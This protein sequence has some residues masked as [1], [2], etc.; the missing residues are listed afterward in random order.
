MSEP[1]GG[2]PYSPPG[3]ASYPE[4]P[5]VAPWKEQP[6]GPWQMN[7][8]GAFE[9][10]HRNPDWLVSTLLGSLCV[11]STIL[12]PAL[13]A[14]VLNGYV[15]ESIELLH[16][17]NGSYYPKFDFGRFV[18]YL[19]RGVGP[20]LVG[21][22]LSIP[23]VIVI[24]LGYFMLFAGIFAVGAAGEENPGAA[25]LGILLAFVVF[26]T[27]MTFVMIAFNFLMVPLGLRGGVSSDIGQ[28]FNFGWAFDFIKKTWLEMLLVFLFQFAV[29]LVAALLM[30]LT[31]YIGSL[32]AIGYVS[33]IA[34][35]LQFQLYRVYL[36]RGGEPIPFKPA[37]LPVP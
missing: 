32:V 8:F 30:I 19:L 4:K 2:N 31:C 33:L 13:G 18:E 27:V 10:I 6:S 14:I 7:Y 35:W 9:M 16:R 24:F 11:L 29:G 26:F 28:S 36:S 20:F 17:T 3:P 1:F 34:A 22:V 23:L 12:I 15:Y 25:G 21:L 5:Q 37:P